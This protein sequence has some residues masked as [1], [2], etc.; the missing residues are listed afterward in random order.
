MSATPAII[1]DASD[2]R[3][4]NLFLTDEWGR[5]QYHEVVV[6]EVID[7]E[8]RIIQ[9][10]FTKTEPILNPEWDSSRVYTP[11]LKRL[12]WVAVGI[13]GKLLV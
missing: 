11:R 8:G 12:E 7:D 13:V 5:V 4:H 10:S 3:W 2:L 6:P 9:P 1:A